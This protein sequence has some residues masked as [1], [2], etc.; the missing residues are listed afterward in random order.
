VGVGVI[1]ADLCEREGLVVP[2]FTAE[3]RKRLSKMTPQGSGSMVINPVEIGLGRFGISEYYVEALRLVDADP[4]VDL[5]VTFL[6]PEQYVEH[7]KEDWVEGAKKSLVEAAK[8]VK[9]PL[10]VVFKPGSSSR[11][12]EWNGQ[13]QRACQEA[14]V[15]TYK[16]L[17][18]AI[19]AASK[20][21][22]YHEF[23][24]RVCG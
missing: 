3:T 1:T 11:V 20:L 21:I 9:K 5:T 17:E 7:I 14:G 10:I 13:L 24:S 16:S 6:D 18:T 23:K 8:Q 12:F 19:R 15:P 4:H 2:E 22:G